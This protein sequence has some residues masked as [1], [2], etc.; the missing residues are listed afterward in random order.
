VALNTGEPVGIAHAETLTRKVFSKRGTQTKAGGGQTAK[1]A[2]RESERWGRGAEMAERAVGSGKAIHVMDREADSYAL[3]AQLHARRMRFVVRCYHDRRARAADDDAEEEWSNLRPLAEA[4]TGLLKREVR[5]SE[6]KKKTAPR[7]NRFNPPRETRDAT[8]QFAAMRVTVPAPKYVTEGPASIDL[9]VVRVWEE[10]PPAD[11]K[12]VEWL[13]YTNESIATAN[14]V[15]R[16]VDIYR[17]RWLIE[18]FFKALKTGCAYET[19]EFESLE[20]LRTLLAM[21]LPIACELLWLRN[22]S[23]EAPNAPATDV[24]SAAQIE[25][26]KAMS[27]RRLPERPTTA[28]AL[29]AVAELGGHQKSNGPPGWQVLYRGL[30][31]L[32]TYESSWQRAKGATDRPPG[33][34]KM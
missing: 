10:H 33:P 17:M 25:V 21:S 13:L 4:M 18:E 31:T 8:L 15:A 32:L 5:L 6:R 22:R 7:A 11:E 20:A 14:A 16:V 3:L 26:L 29:A 19:R 28:E 30:K 1:W 34:S 27:N 24:L 12:P 23:R 2:D 9:N